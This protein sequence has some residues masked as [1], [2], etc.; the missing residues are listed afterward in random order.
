ML[1][2]LNHIV[3]LGDII[4]HLL[5]D[6]VAQFDLTLD[7][8]LFCSMKEARTIS[9]VIDKVSRHIAV[10]GKCQMHSNQTSH[11][12]SGRKASLSIC[13]LRLKQVYF[14]YLYERFILLPHAI[15]KGYSKRSVFLFTQK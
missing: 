10:H 5:D 3:F 7:C 2:V 9:T 11:F 8:I 15:N 6:F 14:L 13:Q 1:L 12:L 4:L